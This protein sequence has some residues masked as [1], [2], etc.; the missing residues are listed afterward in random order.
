METIYFI[1]IEIFCMITAID[2]DLVLEL[3]ADVSV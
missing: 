3:L 1:H 2:L